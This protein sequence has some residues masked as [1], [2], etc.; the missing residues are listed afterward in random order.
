MWPIP[1][2]D[3]KFRTRF[4]RFDTC[5]AYTSWNEKAMKVFWTDWGKQQ[6]YCILQNAIWSCDGTFASAPAGFNQVFIIGIEA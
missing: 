5:D 6:L 4:L 1:I 3:G 2:N